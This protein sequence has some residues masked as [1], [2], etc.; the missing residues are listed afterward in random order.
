MNDIKKDIIIGKFL[1]PYGIKGYLKL[2]SFTENS[3]NIFMYKSFYIYNKKIKYINFQYW[4][5]YKN[6]F[7]VKIRNIN[8]RTNATKIKNFNIKINY[9]DLPKLNKE[10]F[11]LQDIIK[12]KVV[13]TQNYYFGKIYNIIQTKAND[14]IEVKKKSYLNKYITTLIP[15][16]QHKIVK[17]IDI[18]NK[19]IL[20]EWDNNIF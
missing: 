11:Y 14:I 16:I 7:I 2:L 13:N 19:T 8:D 1:Q 9:F 17:N 5:K 6:I 12:C 18:I 4:E 20:V 10:N 3:V 15:L